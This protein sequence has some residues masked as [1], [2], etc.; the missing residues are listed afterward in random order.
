MENRSEDRTD[1]GKCVNCGAAE[2]VRGSF[3]QKLECRAGWPERDGSGYGVW[4]RVRLNEAQTPRSCIY[5]HLGGYGG[6]W[7]P[8]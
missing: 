2:W 3:P 1:D 4:P 6:F 7:L 8:D 5:G